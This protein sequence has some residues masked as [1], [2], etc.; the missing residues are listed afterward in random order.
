ME[1]HQSFVV[2]FFISGWFVAV[3]SALATPS[4]RNSTNITDKTTFPL[5]PNYVWPDTIKALQ[6]MKHTANENFPSWATCGYSIH[7]NPKVDSFFEQ[8][9]Y[10]FYLI[11]DHAFCVTDSFTA[12]YRMITVSSIILPIYELFIVSLL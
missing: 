2:C 1:T 9:S 3:A 8:V 11:W 12:L 5:V 4:M 10:F 7:N 6:F